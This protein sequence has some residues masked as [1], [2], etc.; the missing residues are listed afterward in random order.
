MEKIPIDG[1]LKTDTLK[2][3]K[4]EKVILTCNQKNILRYLCDSKNFVENSNC[5]KF[6]TDRKYNYF[7]L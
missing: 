3:M 4:K 6:Q 2:K 7:V 1:G 5:T